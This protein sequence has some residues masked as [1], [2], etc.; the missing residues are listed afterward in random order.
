[1]PGTGKTVTCN[2][3]IVFSFIFR[4][5]RTSQTDDHISRLDAF[6]GDQPRFRPTGSHGTVYRDGPYYITYVGGFT[7]EVFYIDSEF[8]QNVEEFL[9]AADDHFQHFSWN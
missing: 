4:L 3:A 7:P 2:P 5:A 9:C 1:M 8:F 6:V